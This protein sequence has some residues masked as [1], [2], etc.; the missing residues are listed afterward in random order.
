MKRPAHDNV[1]KL[2]AEESRS[3]IYSE[4]FKKWRRISDQSMTKKAPYTLCAINNESLINITWSPNSRS[5]QRSLPIFLISYDRP[6]N[7][8]LQ[9]PTPVCTRF[10]YTPLSG[11]ISN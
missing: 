10:V 2:L 8:N 4:G 3:P 1:Q 9:F 5:L 7:R 6:I 11:H